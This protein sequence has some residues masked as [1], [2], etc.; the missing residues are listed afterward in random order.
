MLIQSSFQKVKKYTSV[1]SGENKLGQSLD[2]N[3]NDILN[4][5]E[6]L[7][8]L[9]NLKSKYIIL[10]ICE[11]VGVRAN[12]GKAGADKAYDTFLS[13]FVNV[14]NNQFIAS[15]AIF[16]LGEIFVTDIQNAS[17][18][19]N[20]IDKLRELCAK[21]DE[22]V[23]PVIESIVM[24]GKIPIIIGGG[25]N[26]AYGNIKG[27]A[28][29]L[30]KK[31]DVLN[32]DPH[33]DFRVE[34]GRHSGNGFRYA[35]S[36]NY[37]ERYGVWGLHENYNNQSILDSFSQNPNLFFESF[38]NMLRNSSISLD[39]FLNQFSNEIGLEL[40]LDAV[41]NMPTSAKT[42][43]GFAEEEVFYFVYKIST[44]K[45]VLYYHLTEGSPDDSNAYIVGKFL[46]YLVTSIIKTK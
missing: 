11:D 43:V 13:Y 27:T 19:V 16:L 39:Q 1:R 34:E 42:P 36:E 9:K 21:I 33:A 7:S 31:I 14:Q 26:N 45:R 3:K 6:L 17:K 12:Y 2:I 25:H 5:R 24:S 8:V 46:T 10:G 37:I 23:V 32:I 29:A 22:R 38:D 41:K 15:D 40:D 18:E 4:R 44:S 30:D 28:L 20:N 35:F